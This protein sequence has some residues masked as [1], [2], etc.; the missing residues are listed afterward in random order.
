MHLYMYV[1]IYVY[2]WEKL[3]SKTIDELGIC[4]ASSFFGMVLIAFWK[5]TLH[6][7]Y[8]HHIFIYI[9]IMY[10]ALCKYKKVKGICA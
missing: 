9:Y 2:T 1:Y 10:N 5:S 3:F 7:Y 8:I 4:I 6:I